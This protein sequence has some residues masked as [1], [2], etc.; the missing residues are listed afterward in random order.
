MDGTVEP[1]EL[2]HP[3]ALE[4]EQALQFVA[5]ELHVGRR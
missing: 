1:P 3:G 4:E 5:D 2:H